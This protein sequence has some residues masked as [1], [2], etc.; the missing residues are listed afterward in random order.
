M[1]SVWLLPFTGLVLA[2]MPALGGAEPVRPNIIVI[3]AADRPEA[4]DLASAKPARLKELAVK[5]DAWARRAHVLPWPW[6]KVQP[7]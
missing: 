1:K 5:W 6:D 7:R 3:F 4:H 2:S